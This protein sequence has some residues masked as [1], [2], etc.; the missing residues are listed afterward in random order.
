MAVLRAR[1]RLQDADSCSA[2]GAAAV[3]FHVELAL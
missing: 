2:D 1:M 3:L